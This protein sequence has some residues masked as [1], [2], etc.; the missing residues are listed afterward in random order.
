MS[1]ACVHVHGCVCVS[2]SLRV[3]VGGWVG[4]GVPRPYFG[5]FTAML[6]GLRA[7]ARQLGGSGG[8][9]PQENFGFQEF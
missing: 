1:I 9:P 7:Q 3:L 5:G 2:V 8:M 6:R 4:R